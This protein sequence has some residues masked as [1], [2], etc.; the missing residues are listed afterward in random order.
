MID[1][2]AHPIAAIDDGVQTEDEAVEFCRIAAADGITTLVATPH[3]REGMFPNRRAGILEALERLRARLQSEGVD[4]RLAPGAEVYL[5]PDLSARVRSGEYLTLNDGGRYLL[6][7]LPGRHLPAGIEDM[8]YRLRLDGLTPVIAHP[9]R[10]YAFQEDPRRFA[11]LIELGALGQ[12][13]GGSLLGHFGSRA[14]EAAFS[15]LRDGLAHVLASDAHN[16]GLRAP[17]L[18]R[19]VEE[20]AALVGAEAARQMVEGTP[21]AILQGEEIETPSEPTAARRGGWREWLRSLGR[22]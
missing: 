10:I 5:E 4:L 16:T 9:E 17:R 20:A 13:T 1:L 7:E 6:L 22:P 11:R 19:A 21:R 2:H 3:I 14:Q 12:L 15:M 8:V 18:S